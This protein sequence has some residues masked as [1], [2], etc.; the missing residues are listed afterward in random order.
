MPQFPQDTRQRTDGHVLGILG[1]QLPVQI[2]QDFQ[3]YNR[4]R[5]LVQVVEH[6]NQTFPQLHIVGRF[7]DGVAVEFRGVLGGGSRSQRLHAGP[8]RLP[9]VSFFGRKLGKFRFLT[10]TRQCG[11]G[12][13]IVHRLVDVSPTLGCFSLEILVAAG[14]QE[15]QP[16]AGVTTDHFPL[17]RGNR[18]LALRRRPDDTRP[19]AMEQEF[20]AFTTVFFPVSHPLGI[21]AP[22]FGVALNAEVEY[23]V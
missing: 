3:L 20:T 22:M 14:D 8:E 9:G 7:V 19:H 16:L 15:L 12:Q 10:H 18:F 11:F 23:H 17:G 6:R 4:I 5:L 21:I 2:G 1:D 13:P